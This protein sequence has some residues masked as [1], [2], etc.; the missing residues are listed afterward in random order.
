MSLAIMSVIRGIKSWLFAILLINKHLSFFL[1]NFSRGRR[2]DSDNL[3]FAHN[4]F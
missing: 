3:L 1:L 4:W 2:F